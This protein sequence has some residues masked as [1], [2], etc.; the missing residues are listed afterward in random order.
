[1]SE[2]IV[3]NI[4]DQLYNLESKVKKADVYPIHK[5]LVFDD[6][7]DVDDIYGWLS[8]H[9]DFKKGD[10]LLDAGCGVG[11]GSCLLGRLHEIKIT[12]ISLSDKE[13]DKANAFAS[14][15][16]LKGRV[17][18]EKRSFDDLPSEQFDKIIAVESV[19]HSL[20]LSKTLKVMK[21]SLVPGGKLHIV[22]DFYGR[23]GLTGDALGYKND[24]NLVDVFRL[25]DFYT[26]LNQDHT[27]FY[28]LTQYIPSKSKFRINLKFLFNN[29]LSTFRG[30]DKMNIY[31]IFRGGYFLDRLYIDGLMHYGLLTYIKPK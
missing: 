25:K 4:Y 17:T 2:A 23:S 20:N 21:S 9:I 31:K 7:Q 10:H 11:F 24:W 19:K 27:S 12:G 5:R 26:I 13:V 3:K 30:N 22:E 28:D 29:I 8:K 18:F 14:K 1:M 15:T 6:D 16:G